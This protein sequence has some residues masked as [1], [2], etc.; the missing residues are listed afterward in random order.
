MLSILTEF[1]RWGLVI[2]MDDFGTGYSSLGYLSRFPFDKIKIDQSFVRDMARPENIAIVRSVIGLSRALGMKVIAEGIETA[3]Q[4]QVLF[5]E[6]CREMQ[7]YFFSRPRP[8]GELPK[9]L[10]EIAGRW[11]GEFG[12]LPDDEAGRPRRL[13][14]RRPDSPWCRTSGARRRRRRSSGG[15]P[16]RSARPERPALPRSR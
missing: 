4:M 1:R 9:M 3:D 13:S 16:S 8:A 5:N 7:G 6:G 2:S 14:Q 11:S 15:R 10:T 12:V